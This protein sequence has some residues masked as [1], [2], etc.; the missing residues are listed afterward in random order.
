MMKAGTKNS[1]MATDAE[2][3][4]MNHPRG[5]RVEVRSREEC[6][7]LKL[8]QQVIKENAPALYEGRGVDAIR[9]YCGVKFW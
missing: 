9:S 8:Y 3:K 1:P 6:I 5:C 7:S 2:T 4:K